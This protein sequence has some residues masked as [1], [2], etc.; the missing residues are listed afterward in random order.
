M[1]ISFLTPAYNSAEWIQTML[2]SIPKDYA[3]EIIVCD[4]Q[5]TDNT[6]EILQEYKKDCPQL[7]IL[8]NE[9]NMGQVIHTIGA[10]QKQQ[11]I[12]YAIIDSDDMYL[13]SY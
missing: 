13:P 5:S 12:I 2:D 9:N 7:K 3:F 11:A 1:K 6:L 4:D 8:I 10:L